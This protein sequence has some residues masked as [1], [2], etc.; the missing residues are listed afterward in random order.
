MRQKVLVCGASGFM[1]RNIA[2]AFAALSEQYEVYSISKQEVVR[3]IGHPTAITADLTNPKH[4]AGLFASI[5]PDIVIQAAATTSGAKDIV[6][7]PYIHTTDNAVMNS[8]ILRACYENNV[9]Q[10]VF[11]SCGVM[12]QP[13]DE[14][15]REEDYNEHDEIFPAYFGVGWTKV[16]VEKMCEFYSRLGRTKHTVLRHSNTYG[17]WDKYDYE[18][19]HVVGATIRKVMDAEEHG[20]ISVWGTGEETARDLVYVRDVVRAVMLAVEKQKEAYLLCNIGAGI[21]ITVRQIVETIVRVSKKQLEIVYDSSKPV[22]ATRLALDYSKAYA[23]LGWAP[24]T[25]FETGIE[26]TLAWYR[27]EY[28]ASLHQ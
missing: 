27:D 4:V 23:Y 22:I 9:R 25:S 11:L 20:K 13:G 8:L 3:L 28:Q 6:E 12:Y 14:L 10:F 5:K 2:A 26:T 21:A 7:R 24:R 1:G 18:Y 16:Y 15:R 19:S 17:P